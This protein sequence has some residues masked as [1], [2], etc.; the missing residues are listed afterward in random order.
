MVVSSESTVVNWGVIGG[1][2][3]SGVPSTS[4]SSGKRVVQL[5]IKTPTNNVIMKFHFLFIY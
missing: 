2:V 4:A 5:K 1:S 3:G